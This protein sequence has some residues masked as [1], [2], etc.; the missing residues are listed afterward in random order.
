MAYAG[1]FRRELRLTPLEKLPKDLTGKFL[2][3]FHDVCGIPLADCWAM[4]RPDSGST[5]R[6][7]AVQASR[8]LNHYKRNNPAGIADA[9][10][11]SGIT[12]QDVTDMAK[13]MFHAVKWAWNPKTERRE[14][15]EE[16]DWN[17]RNRAIG[18]ILELAKLDTKVR[19]ELVLGAAENRK[20]HLNTGMK[21]DTIQEWME[22]MK[23]RDQEILEER[24]VAAREMKL[25]AAGR[26]IIQEKGE[27]TADE[28]RQ[29]AL[30]AGYTGDEPDEEADAAAAYI[31]ELGADL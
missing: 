22:Y 31:R 28:Y 18:R 1:Q 20:M 2:W 11:A 23:G 6:A 5:G 21:F 26:Q 29:A 17:A 30:D 12:I 8:Y 19:D 16:P 25:I 9:L 4:V 7:A 27:K 24:A 13:Q 14:P 10:M 3:F 15:T